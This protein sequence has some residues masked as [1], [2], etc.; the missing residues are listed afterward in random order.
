MPGRRG[1]RKPDVAKP[2]GK[3]RKVSRLPGVEAAPPK[4]MP[5]SKTLN[6]LFLKTITEL[7]MPAQN[8]EIMMKQS[9]AKKWELVQLNSQ[10]LDSKE[11][12]VTALDWVN[13]LKKMDA[14]GTPEITAKDAK[15]LHTALRT[16]K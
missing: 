15:A 2:K 3:S 13:K 6:A 14:L 7:N 9:D 4:P 8:K 5:D 16:G 1:T 12:G 11:D 10:F